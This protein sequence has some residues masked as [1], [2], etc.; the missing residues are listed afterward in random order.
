[1]TLGDVCEFKVNNPDAD[2]WLISKGTLDKV[3]TP[4]KKFSPENIGVKVTRT[5]IL[6]PDFLFYYMQYMQNSGLFQQLASGTTEIKHIL[7]S[8]ISRIPIQFSE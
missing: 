1:M 7:T 4:T 2:F 3:G 5:D 6:Y 8:D